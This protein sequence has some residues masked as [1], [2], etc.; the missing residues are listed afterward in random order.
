MWPTVAATLQGLSAADDATDVLLDLGRLGARAEAAALLA[1]ADVTLVVARSRLS[2]IAGA[3]Q[4]VHYLTSGG[5]RREPVDRDAIGCL[6]VGEGDPYPA[7]AIGSS[8]GLPVL[9]VLPWDPAAAQVFSD[10][11]AAPRSFDRGPLRRSAASAAV[12]IRDHARRTAA[13]SV[14][15]LASEPARPAMTRTHAPANAKETAHG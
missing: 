13:A 11:L 2:S 7:R 3:H 15:P 14:R 10:G 9:A 5:S 8:L 6:L 4:A 12:L 1:V